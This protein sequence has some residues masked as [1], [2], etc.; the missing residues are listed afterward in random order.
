MS[1]PNRPPWTRWAVCLF[2]LQ[3]FAAC[4]GAHT[5]VVL[6]PDTDGG[7]GAVSVEKGDRL[8][9]LDAP[10]TAAD[11]NQRGSIT[12][13]PVTEAEVERDF[14]EALAAQP[15]EPVTFV[16]YFEEGSTEVRE[17]S[18]PKLEALFREVAARQAV[19]VQV[20]GHT[21]RVGKETDNDRLSAERAE[22]IKAM[23]VQKGL[24]AQ[25]IRA[26]GRGEREPLVTT[27]DD[28]KEPRNRRVEIIVR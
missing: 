17:T 14:S 9:V 8:V 16:L 12:T 20:T 3:L 18:R 11:V 13:G 27:E 5:H 1:N 4:G 22:A 25:F 26:V 6:L 21:D 19:E 2:F 24:R 28:V 23:L 7:T 15:P 10:M